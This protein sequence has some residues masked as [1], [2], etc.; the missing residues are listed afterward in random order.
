MITAPDVPR[1]TGGGIALCH[2]CQ[3][4]VYFAG[5]F[6]QLLIQDLKREA[7]AKIAER[8]RAPVHNASE[9]S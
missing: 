1:L 6:L 9:M 3:R 5:G 7:T 2:T 8:A 4:S